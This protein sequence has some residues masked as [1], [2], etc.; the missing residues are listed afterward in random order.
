MIKATP[1][2]CL[3]IEAFLR[4][5]IATS[6]FPLSNLARYGMKGGHPRAVTFWAKWQQAA[7][8][9]VL[10]VSDEGI[11]FPQCTTAPW[12]DAKVVMAGQKVKGLLGDSVQVAALV[13][14]LGLSA[15]PALHHVEPLYVLTL[16]KLRMPDVDGF[17]I[18]PLAEAPDEL[19]IGWRSAYLKE[20]LPMPG[21]DD[22]KKA[23]EDIAN[24]REAGSHVVLFKG[25]TPVA[26]TGFNATLSD[27]VQIGGV[28]VP[29]AGRSRGMARRA[30][31]LHLAQA[32]SE[33][34]KTACLFAASP[35]AARAYEAVGFARCGDFT[36]LTY[37]EPQVVYG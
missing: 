37:Q 17:S 19:V 21:Q 5:R 10:T 26:M 20:V 4:A 28:Y 25:E 31:A 16:D 30:V 29:P 27:A 32:R 3:A 9:D 18:A 7:L 15:K 11:L 36:I 23:A 34:I 14:A 6:M 22:A 13:D 2:D 33:G 12:G 8:T 35:Q 24:Y 1:A